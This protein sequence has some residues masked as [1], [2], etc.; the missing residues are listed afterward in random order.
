MRNSIRAILVTA[1]AGGTAAQAEVKSANNF[2]LE[3][4]SSVGI[5]G[6]VRTIYSLIASPARWWSSER[7]CSSD[8]A[9]LSLD[10]KPSKP[11]VTVPAT[12]CI[13]PQ[14]L[15]RLIAV[16]LLMHSSD[17]IT[18]S[19][20]LGGI[21]CLER[22]RCAMRAGFSLFHAFPRAFS[23]SGARAI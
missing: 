12:I 5:V 4:V 3:V 15:N 19:E 11:D 22:H 21:G 6:D 8:A 2:R 9:N 17:C 10:T 13:R 23:S 16:S 7:T 18:Y 20:P 14:Y 1:L